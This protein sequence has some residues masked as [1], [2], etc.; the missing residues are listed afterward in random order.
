MGVIVK[1]EPSFIDLLD[2][3]FEN[4]IKI[5][6]HSAKDKT[7]LENSLKASGEIQAISISEMDQEDVKKEIASIGVEK[8]QEK[9]TAILEST[10]QVN[11]VNI[12]LPVLDQLLELFG[13]LLIRAKQLEHRIEGKT[14]SETKDI[15]F[16]MQSFMFN[17]Q[18]IV[19]QM[20][21]VPISTMFRLYPRM[22]R[23]LAQREGKRVK[24]NLQHNDIKLDRK[25]LN[26]TGEIIN[27]L[28][29]NSVY[30]GIETEA[31]R[32][33]SR[34]PVEGNIRLETK[35]E[36]NVLFIT[37]ED[38]GHGID[39]D[40]I[41]RAAIE[42]G[43]YSGEELN[44]MTPEQIQNLIFKPNFSTAS[45][46]NLTSGRGLG[47]SIVKQKV[48]MLGGSLSFESEVN[49]GT[50]FII[51]IPITRSI[52]RA[53]IIQ[54][55]AQLYSIALDDV[56]ELYEFKTSDIS[57]INNQEYVILT[58]QKDLLKIYRLN[59]LFKL[60]QPS[61]NT[62]PDEYI[63]IVHIKKGDRNYG[64]VVDEF[65]KESEIVI[66]KISDGHEIKGIS[67][68]AV[69]DDGTVSLII[70]PFSVVV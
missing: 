14:D 58:D 49:M 28:L 18:D 51:Q 40:K 37:I 46:A 31:E 38:D 7:S 11:S 22:V 15:L 54:A 56:Q 59:Q 66:K 9:E 47:L 36:N 2:G 39:P 21:L 65:I 10:T 48:E 23:G 17:L 44:E 53:L 29:R 34:K 25:M 1:T 69:L 3:K 5:I 20:Q 16:Q 43:L 27:H 55:G 63:K 19:L 70:D 64:L 4:D 57:V 60:D 62:P 35:I 30:H 8:E 24:I 45:S 32:R 42:K 52:I 6:F 12:E 41:A 67:G 68:A 13:E 33:S 61:E 26:Q 50:K